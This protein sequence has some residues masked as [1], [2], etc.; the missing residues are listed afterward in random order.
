M[1]K[2]V[3]DMTNKNINL[4]TINTEGG[5]AQI[6]DVYN[7][8]NY[9][10]G[11]TSLLNEYSEQIKD[12]EKLLYDFKPKTALN[13]FNS[14]ETRAYEKP[15]NDNNKIKSTLKFLKGLCKSELN[16][17][18]AKECALEFIE[19]YNLN[20]NDY[21]L[22]NRAVVEYLNV[23]DFVK[24]QTLAD[25][26]LE[27]EEYN[28][29]AWFVK[30]VLSKD[31]KD[32]L[33]K[34]PKIVFENKGFQL[35][36][37]N[38]LLKIEKEKIFENLHEYGLKFDNNLDNLNQLTF[39]NKNAWLI[40]IN[41]SI[42][43]LINQNPL[44]YIA[45]D[46]F[47]T[48]ETSEIKNLCKKLEIF[49]DKLK[50]SE[51]AHSIIHSEFIFNYL[52]YT[53]TNNPE[54]AKNIEKIYQSIENPIWFQTMAICQVL[55]HIEDYGKSLLFLEKFNKESND[56]H[57]EFFMFKSILLHLT[58]QDD[59]I[60]DLFVEYIETVK[61]F[62]ERHFFNIYN[63][64]FDIYKRKS[65][66]ESI[67]KALEKIK[68]EK[69]INEELFNLFLVT[70]EIKY[71]GNI[72]NQ[73]AYNKLVELS[74]V[75]FFD[76]YLRN[77]ITNNF[78]SLG[79][80][81]EAINYIESYVVK[82]KISETL[83][84]Y[85]ILLNNQIHDKN[86]EERGKYKELINLLEFWRKNSPYIDEYL[87]K[88]EHNLYTQINRLD[89]LE[90]IDS[91]LFNEF[92]NNEQYLLLYLNTLERSNN[93]ELIQSISS[94]IKID[95]E[96]ENFGIIISNIL[97][98][99][100]VDK[101]GFQILYNLAKNKKNISARRSYFSNSIALDN[102]FKKYDTVRANNWVIYKLNENV[103]KIKIL[104]TSDFHKKFIDKS[105][106]DT[107]TH[108]SNM[109]GRINTITILEIFNEPLNLFKEIMD[110]IKSPVNEL[111][112]E[113]FDAPTDIKEF[114]KQLIE[115]F[116]AIGT[117]EKIE[118]EKSLK[119][120]YNYEIG[121]SEITGIT[122]RSDFI[123]S[124]L[125][126]TN[127]PEYSFTTIPNKLTN[128]IDLK[129]DT[130][131]IL[132]FSTIQ[133]FYFL[134][135]EF[136]FSF[137]HHFIISYYVKNEI[138]E[139]IT[140][141]KH[142]PASPM[143]VQITLEGVKPYFNP[144]NYKEQRITFL[145]SLLE[146]VSKNCKVDYVEE[147]LDSLPKLEEQIEKKENGIFKQLVDYMHLSIRNNGFR[148]ISSDTTTFLFNHSH[149]F[150]HNILNPEKYL[151]TF[152][153]EKCDL[154]FYRYLLK[155]KY[156]GI[157]INLEVLKNEFID[158]IAGKENFYPEAINNLQFTLNVNPDII[159]TSTKF[160]KYIYLMLTLSNLDKNRFSFQVLYLTLNGMNKELIKA[161][162][163]NIQKE[164]KL[165]GDYY[166]EALNQ[167][168][169]AN[170]N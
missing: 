117:N 164:F 57:Y 20:K 88:I 115:N 14:L 124:Y 147:K 79:K 148:L 105:V 110:E 94:N 136:N 82:S 169:L 119:K 106:G 77:L 25:K 74:K 153:P 36:I 11:L 51:I 133:L 61:A 99:N 100:N 143:T 41:L 12:I 55:N 52:K 160:I 102:F 142:S 134:E 54:F 22:R 35:S 62:D 32:F 98:R 91:I 101:K 130:N 86:D 15:V 26:I 129:N 137:K 116:G 135:K 111:G 162:R 42:Q 71:I 24:A 141:E 132:D 58:N 21:K 128:E 28:I 53:T 92:P 127:N 67:I 156:I 149:N 31:I 154:E 27:T 103:E 118:N 109:T 7:I 89:V 3:I 157:N 44:Q 108:L 8:N 151:Q 60:D 139:E 38:Q 16:N 2:L 152:Y 90:E 10:E 163:I 46:Y 48:N 95:F 168:D 159:F 29:N 122:F 66:T 126:L 81:K 97:L 150:K 104:S 39:D 30:A 73:N 96:D 113:S 121:F 9:F 23:S 50:N 161:F 40:N 19:A 167:F 76:E 34:I 56:L 107:F 125:I 18:D 83:R 131:F 146:W 155:S 72:D 45:G 123:N 6:G 85:I 120:Y 158:F 68:P 138:E 33:K 37:I 87:L 65:N 170:K 13:L 4:G 114:E 78:E 63:A 144:E 1:F 140:K 80:R 17:F 43:K 84:L 93:P 112:F 47:I 165:L 64:F 59:K 49:I 69:F 5:P 145:N 75:D 70:T 166:D